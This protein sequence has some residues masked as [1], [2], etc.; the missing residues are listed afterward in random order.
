VVRLASISATYP[1]ADAAKAHERLQ[2]GGVR[3]RLVIVP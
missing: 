3:G 1:L 2:D